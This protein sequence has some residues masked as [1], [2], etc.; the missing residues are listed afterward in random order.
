ML[1]LLVALSLFLV[2]LASLTL[3]QVSSLALSHSNQET[4]MAIGSAV[5]VAEALHNEP[6]FEAIYVRWNAIADDDPVGDPA[7]GNAFDVEGLEATADDDDGR[8]GE[9]V[10]PGDGSQLLESGSD[11][12][13]GMPRDL[14]F[15]GEITDD[16]HST[17]YAILPVLLRVRWRGSKGPQEL[18]LVTTLS[19]R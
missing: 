14:D 19:E 17:D 3:A 2:G 15:D 16:D 5:D 4:S 10:F 18:Q 6:S 8:V 11:R 12:L 13:L 9:V 1:E 7:P